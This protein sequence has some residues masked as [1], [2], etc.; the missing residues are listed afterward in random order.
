MGAVGYPRPLPGRATTRVRPYRSRAG[1]V[2]IP[3]NFCNLVGYTGVN[4]TS[5]SYPLS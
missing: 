2:E 4:T 5:G 1:S 3:N